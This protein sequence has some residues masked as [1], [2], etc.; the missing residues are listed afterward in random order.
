MAGHTAQSNW[1]PVLGG[2][3][4]GN[5]PVSSIPSLIS[6]WSK[7]R[8]DSFSTLLDWITQSLHLVLQALGLRLHLSSG[9][10]R[11]ARA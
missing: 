8:G 1:A 11:G 10:S 7:G 2:K 9:R 5:L 6:H 4:R 3:G